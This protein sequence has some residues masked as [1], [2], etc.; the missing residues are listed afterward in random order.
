MN[1][2]NR[3]SNLKKVPPEPAAKLLALSELE[4]ETSL[5]C[6]VSASVEDVLLELEERG[7]G[8]D[9]IRVMSAAL[10]SRERVW[11]SCLAARDI[12]GSGPENETPCLRTAEAWVFRP[13][14]ESRRAVMQAMDHVSP[15][16]KTVYCAMGVMYSDDT[17]GPGE[18]AQYPAPPGGSAIAAFA[19]N[20]E[21]LAFRKDIWNQH[22]QTLIDRALDIAR[23]G[24][25]KGEKDPK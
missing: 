10:P 20:I 12:L 8:L 16:D 18:M 3:F 22:I 1:V 17:L 5:T 21:A 7:A 9:M 13:S 11:W 24:N 15:K 25:G 4:L 23:G 19:M 2:T 6:P 14:D